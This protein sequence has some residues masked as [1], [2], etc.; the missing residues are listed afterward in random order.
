MYRALDIQDEPQVIAAMRRASVREILGDEALWGRDIA[1][2]TG[3]VE[4]RPGAGEEGA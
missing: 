2:L 4:A 1:H 3:A